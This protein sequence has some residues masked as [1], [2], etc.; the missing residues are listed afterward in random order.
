VQQLGPQIRRAIS[1]NLEDECPMMELTAPMHRVSELST[2]DEL[3]FNLIN[4]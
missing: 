1:G 3:A 4:V 2:G